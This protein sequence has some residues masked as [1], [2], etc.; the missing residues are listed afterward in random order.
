MPIKK[1]TQ[2]TDWDALPVMLTVPEICKVLRISES[3]CLKLLHSGDLP[4]IRIGNSW[5]LNKEHLRGA[6][7]QT[8]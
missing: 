6:L 4:G 7:S 8:A 5:R 3:T 2:C 1:W